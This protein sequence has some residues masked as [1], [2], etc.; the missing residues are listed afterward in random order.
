M[1]AG[2]QAASDVPGGRQAVAEFGLA[3]IVDRREAPAREFLQTRIELDGLRCCVVSGVV[4]A[5]H[6]IQPQEIA[7][8]GDLGVV[9]ERLVKTH[10][11]MRFIEDR[12]DGGKG[13][14]IK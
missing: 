8:S 4:I 11:E 12:P 5:G 2:R 14:V 7:Q 10:M 3:E 9:E 1:E 13:L 6:K